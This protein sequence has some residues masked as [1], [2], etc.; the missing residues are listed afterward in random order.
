MTLDVLIEN[1]TDGHYTAT[2]LAWPNY[3]A[4]GVTEA[5]AIARLRASL[6]TRLGGSKLV[7]LELPDAS[8]SNPWLDLTDRLHT[9]PLLDEVDEAIARYRRELDAAE[10]AAA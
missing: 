4:H 2:L 5:E 8:E 9:N 6:A 3:Q 7:Q 1:Q 10:D